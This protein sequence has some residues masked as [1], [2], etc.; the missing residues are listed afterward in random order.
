MYFLRSTKDSCIKLIRNSAKLENESVLLGDFKVD[1]EERLSVFSGKDLEN[2][3]KELAALAFILCSPTSVLGK[4]CFI[5]FDAG[6]LDKKNIEYDSSDCDTCFDML[7]EK[8]HYNILGLKTDK[9]VSFFESLKDY[10]KDKKETEYVYSI[11]KDETKELLRWACRHK[12]ILVTKI[13]GDPLDELAELCRESNIEY[14]E[15]IEKYDKQY[16]FEKER[17]EK[18]YLKIHPEKIV[19]EPV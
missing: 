1:S 8:L 17:I 14:P 9:L 3:N 11:K 15:L 18:R 2:N 7:G 13:K 19:T 4:Y 6:I 16:N 10:F 12:R 5:V